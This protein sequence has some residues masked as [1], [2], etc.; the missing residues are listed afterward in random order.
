MLGRAI[1]KQSPIDKQS[2]CS[3][4]ALISIGLYRHVPLQ[5]LGAEDS[6]TPIQTSIETTL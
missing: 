6:G 2:T 5:C 3:A 4:Q 1:G